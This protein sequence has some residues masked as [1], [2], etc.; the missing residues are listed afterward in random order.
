MLCSANARAGLI[1]FTFDAVTINSTN[2]AALPDGATPAAIETY[3]NA[4]LTASGSSLQVTSVGSASTFHG[5]Q[6]GGISGNTGAMGNVT[7]EFVWDTGLNDFHLTFNGN[8]FGMSTDYVV[9]PLSPT[10]TPDFKVEL[11]SPSTVLQTYPASVAGQNNAGNTGVLTFA[12]N[13]TIGF[14]DSGTH[15]FIIDDLTL[16]TTASSAQA[17]AVPAPASLVLLATG[18]PGLLWF[19]RRR[20][21]AAGAAAA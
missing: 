6:T 10:D 7:N 13:N 8:I 2:I 15:D 19:R 16:Y 17:A 9:I 12:A 4:V 18:L 20:P 5:T 21:A 1:T 14:G 3:M 11:G